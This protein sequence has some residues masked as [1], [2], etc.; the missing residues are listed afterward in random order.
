MAMITR[1]ELAPLYL[2][3]LSGRVS[4]GELAETQSDDPFVSRVILPSTT[5][6]EKR[7]PFR[8]RS[9]LQAVAN[10]LKPIAIRIRATKQRIVTPSREIAENLSDLRIR[11]AGS[12]ELVDLCCGT[13]DHVS[14]GFRE[15]GVERGVDSGVVKNVVLVQIAAQK[16]KEMRVH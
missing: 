7:S 11:L 9:I 6:R 16:R 2:G 10:T 4:L 1:R 13:V 3:V 5:S 12:N 14:R 15:K 8:S